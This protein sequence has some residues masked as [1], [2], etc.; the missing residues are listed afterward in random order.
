MSI[1]AFPKVFQ[2]ADKHVTG[3]WDG[4]IEI[5]EKL[6]GSQFV[7]GT[8]DGGFYMRSKGA[9]IYDKDHWVREISTSDIFWMATDHALNLYQK[10]RIHE[11]H[12]FYCETI[13]KPRHN[14]LTYDE[15]PRHGLALF[16][17]TI[18]G[19]PM[20]YASLELAA[21][22]LDIGIANLLYHGTVPDDVDKLA[23]VLHF[24]DEQSDLGG[25]N[26]EGV[27]LKAYREYFVGGQLM[28]I[29]SAKYVS[30]AFKEVHRKDWNRNNSSGGKW[31][32]YKDSFNTE[33]RWN[34]AIQHLRDDGLLIGEPKDIGALI[35]EINRDITEEEKENIMRWLWDHFHK[36]ILR[37]ATRGFPEYYKRMLLEESLN[38][39]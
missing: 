14:V 24:L 28:P 18:D 4:E 13:S 29:M 31:N 39:E 25:P 5:T 34:K 12:V 32:E 17:W 3:I 30:E 22:T 21:S 35:K 23:W 26:I 20:Q 15:I 8:V 1:S 33:A 16:G 19:E 37:T 36:E 9:M 10:G 27:V 38:A 7:F 2:M 6:D 11:G